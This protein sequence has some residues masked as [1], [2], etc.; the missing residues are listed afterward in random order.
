MTTAPLQSLL[1]RA[2]VSVSTLK[3]DGSVSDID[4][5]NLDLSVLK[6]LE[7]GECG[8]IL[9]A[10]G[11]V[12]G[13]MEAGDLAYPVGSTI[14]EDGEILDEDGYVIS[15]GSVFPDKAQELADK[16]KGNLPDVN[17]LDGLE[18]GEGGDILGPDGKPLG[19]ITEG[20]P[21]DLVGM[22]LGSGGDGKIKTL[23]YR[24]RGIPSGLD[25]VGT[26]SLL[27][28]AL[29]TR[30]LIIDSL[31]AATSRQVA[32][33]RL[34]GK[35]ERLNG[36]KRQWQVSAHGVTMTVDT[37]FGGF[38]PLHDPETNAEPTFE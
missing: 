12:V 37:H 36:R 1:L 21:E 9:G 31:A 34:P 16:A 29:G 26:Q 19:K 20:N 24:V 3:I 6:G 4:L 13:K 23:T 2:I 28:A 5:K 33:V 35:Q 7:V 10:D 8:D 38:T 25:K 27:Q 15:R 30:D 14:S 11:E 22:T 18:V 32:T 17:V